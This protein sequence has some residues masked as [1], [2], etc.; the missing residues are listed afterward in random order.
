LLEL[1]GGRTWLEGLYSELFSLLDS[2]MI[3]KAIE[4]GLDDNIS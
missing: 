3:E 1:I 4:R 2:E